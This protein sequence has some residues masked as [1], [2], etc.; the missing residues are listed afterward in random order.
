VGKEKCSEHDDQSEL[1]ELITP[2]RE[3]RETASIGEPVCE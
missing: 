2:G 1:T 3:P